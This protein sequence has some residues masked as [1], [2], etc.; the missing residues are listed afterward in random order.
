MG[1]KSE[2]DYNIPDPIR[3]GDRETRNAYFE[4]T[5]RDDGCRDYQCYQIIIIHAR[6]LESLIKLEH[7]TLIERLHW[8]DKC[9][10]Y[11][12]A[13][14]P[15]VTLTRKLRD[16]LTHEL[17]P[18]YDDILSKMR[19]EWAPTI[20][21]E[22]KE[23]LEETFGVKAELIPKKIYISKRVLRGKWHLVVRG[24][25]NFERMVKELDSVW[26]EGGEEER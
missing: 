11:S 5:V 24:K 13:T 22:E 12:Q 21:K 19:K 15:F 16:E 7:R 17:R 18:V 20:L 10:P 1:R 23:I 14:E 2:Q 3:F 26:K 9:I 8:K 4:Q 25:E 6:E